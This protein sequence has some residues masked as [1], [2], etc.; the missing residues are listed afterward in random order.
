MKTEFEEVITMKNGDE[1]KTWRIDYYAQGR[2]KRKYVKA[3]T[4]GDALKKG[5]VNRSVVDICIVE[6]EGQ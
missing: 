2:Y 5:R 3:A 4:S 6:H 1:V